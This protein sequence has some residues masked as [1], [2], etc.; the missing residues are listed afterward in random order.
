MRQIFARSLLFAAIFQGVNHG[1]PAV[2]L[3]VDANGF[4]GAP[5]VPGTRRVLAAGEAPDEYAVQRGDTLYDICDQLLG[6]P[7]YWPKLWSMNPEIK[8]PHFVF[9]GT[10]I[11]FYPGDLEIPPFLVVTTKVEELP[12][13]TEPAMVEELVFES[14]VQEQIKMASTDT[15]EIVESKDIPIPDDVAREI[16]VA[17]KIFRRSDLTVNLPGFIVDL[18]ADANGYIFAGSQGGLMVDDSGE[19]YLE[20]TGGIAPGSLYTIVR[21]A[22]ELFDDRVG[23]SG[24]FIG[25]RYDL[26]GHVKVIRGTESGLYK[27]QLI[28]TVLPP[29]S[30][31]LLVPFI[32]TRKQFVPSANGPVKELPALVVGFERNIQDFGAEGNFVFLKLPARGAVAE[33]DLVQVFTRPEFVD[34]RP[35]TTFYPDKI[36]RGTVRILDVRGT[37][38]TGYVVQASGPITRWDST[39]S[40]T[41]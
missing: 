27:G 17:G 13:S 36:K 20:E 33:G 31:D 29:E 15:P 14:P 40:K 3:A 23:G 7:D 21:E 2:A 4:A 30:T 6:E 16:M 35:G 24:N 19:V 11:R 41:F 12:V 1:I 38:A 37:I 25:Y 34:P 8:N 39:T 5:P 32:A 18:E 10:K 9:P 26:V 28:E 22:G